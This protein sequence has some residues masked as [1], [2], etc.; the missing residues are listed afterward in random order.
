MKEEKREGRGKERL[1]EGGREER[2]MEKSRS[3][4]IGST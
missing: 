3:T 2:R 4:K 1:K